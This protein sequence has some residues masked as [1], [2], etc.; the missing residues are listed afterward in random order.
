MG[1]DRVDDDMSPLTNFPNPRSQ[2]VP[3]T[4]EGLK[5]KSSICNNEEQCRLPIV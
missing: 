5:P 1:L 4:K 3:K 2:N